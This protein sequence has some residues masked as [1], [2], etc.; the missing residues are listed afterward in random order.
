[1]PYPQLQKAVE[2][3]PSGHANFPSLFRNLGNLYACR[4]DSTH[5]FP[6]V[7]HSI[8]LYCQGAEANG[9]PSIQLAC[10]KKAA[11]L[12]SVHDLSQC[13]V[14]FSLAISLLSD[15]AGLEQTIHH[16]Y[17]NLHGHSDLVKSA[18][19]TA[20]HLNK[21]DFALEWLE[22]GHCLVWNQVNQLHTPIENL[23]VRN[24]SLADRFIAAT[25]AL[26]SYGSCSI[27]SSPSFH[28]TLANDICLQDDTQNHTLYATQYKLLFAEIQSLP[29]FH[30]FLQPPKA[31]D[32]LSSL[33]SSGPVIVFNIHETGCDALTLIVGI[34][35]PLHIP[36]DKFS[37]EQAEQLQKTLQFDLLKQQEVKDQDHMPQHV[38]HSLSSISF[39]LKELWCKVVQ[40]ILEAL[41]YSVRCC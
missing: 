5:Y 20:L 39:V 16:C 30:N 12:S 41:G 35:E 15:V 23:H 9:T 4:F 18:V 40:P 11:I 10:A 34:E 37:L 6:D 26:E 28:P 14:N 3:V 32:I 17:A 13:L 31:T 7:K 21:P 22:Q 2:C 27:L 33:P 38:R 19:A 8:T 25:S 29:D 1:M 36:L 24:P